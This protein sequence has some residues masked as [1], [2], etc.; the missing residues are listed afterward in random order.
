MKANN[1]RVIE[2]YRDRPWL[3]ASVLEGA[4]TISAWDDL[5]AARTKPSRGEIWEEATAFLQPA[6][7]SALARLLHYRWRVRRRSEQL[8]A[9]PGLCLTDAGNEPDG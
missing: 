5:Q 7:L 6:R 1:D 9:T 3:T 4:A 8:R 2:K